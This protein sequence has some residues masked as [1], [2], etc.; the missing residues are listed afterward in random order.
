MRDK[1]RRA[2]KQSVSIFLL[3]ATLSLKILPSEAIEFPRAF[4]MDVTA[5]PAAPLYFISRHLVAAAGFSLSRRPSR[6]HL[7]NEIKRLTAELLRKESELAKARQ[8]LASYEDFKA[9]ARRNPFFVWSGDLLGYVRGGDTD[10]FSRSYIVS[11]GARD[12][13]SKDLPVVWGNIALGRISEVGALYSRVRVLADPRSRVC[14]RFGHSRHEGVLVGTGRQICRVR[15]VPNRV[16]E[17]QIEVDDLVLTSGADGLFPPDLVVG[18]VTRF[19]KRPS[20]PEADVE[21]ELFLDFSR[22]ENCLV[23]KKTSGAAGD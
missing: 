9:V 1:T 17:G 3:I 21:V 18:K 12:G 4:L 8:A 15:F 7:E 5:L 10:I 23:L 20:Q 22:L 14:V 16:E 11:V 19:A 6:Q 13:V 2:L